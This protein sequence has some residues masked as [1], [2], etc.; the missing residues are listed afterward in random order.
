MP[1]VTGTHGRYDTGTSSDGSSTRGGPVYGFTCDELIELINTKWRS[2]DMKL[3]Y[4]KELVA[5]YDR[6]PPSVTEMLGKSILDVLEKSKKLL[7]E[8]KM[9]QLSATDKHEESKSIYSMVV[10]MCQKP[11]QAVAM[12]APVMA[13]AAVSLMDPATDCRRGLITT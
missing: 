12:G 13:A 3:A 1:T 4:A 2:H 6:V 8:L 10:A 11:Q 5:T 9:K 7:K